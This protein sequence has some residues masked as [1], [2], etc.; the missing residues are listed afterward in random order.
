[1]VK[2]SR[3]DLVSGRMSWTDIT[4]DKWR[5]ADEQA[6]TE[7]AATGFCEPFEKEYFR[8]DGSRV[9]VL[10]GAAL[11]EGRRDE[12]VAFVLDLT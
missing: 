4:P 9:S 12:G 7:L 11:F 3:G 8:K 5:A 6:L 1:M 2:Y 10:I